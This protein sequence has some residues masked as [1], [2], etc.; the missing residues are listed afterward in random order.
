MDVFEGCIRPAAGAGC[1][2]PAAGAAPIKFANASFEGAGVGLKASSLSKS[3]TESRLKTSSLDTS[4]SGKPA[5]ALNPVAFLGLCSLP[6]PL[7]PLFA[8]E[9]GFLVVFP[10]LRVSAWMA[11][12]ILPL[13]SLRH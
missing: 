13:V 9:S 10:G 3:P 7:T 6:V 1:I 12:C 4:R 11:C 5:S 2:R 8:A